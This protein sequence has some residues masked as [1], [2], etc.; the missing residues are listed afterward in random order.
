MAKPQQK[1]AQ[2]EASK[3]LRLKNGGSKRRGRLRK[4]RIDD[5]KCIF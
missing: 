5:M 4:S 3:D 1:N 2:Y